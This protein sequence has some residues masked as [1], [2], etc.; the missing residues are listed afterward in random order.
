MEATFV[1]KPGEATPQLIERILSVFAD[2]EEAVTIQVTSQPEPVFDFNTWLEGMESI[3]K[4]TEQVPTPQ[5]MG[6]L[7][8]LIDEMNEVVL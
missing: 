4:R 5:G 2:G 3:R 8:A 7:D 1:V 6:D